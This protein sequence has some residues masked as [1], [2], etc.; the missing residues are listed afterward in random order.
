[1]TSLRERVLAEVRARGLK[2]EDAM[3]RPFRQMA[4]WNTV[5]PSIGVG[6][7]LLIYLSAVG[8]FVIYFVSVFGF[9]QSEANGLGNW[10]WSAMPVAE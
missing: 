1:M 5:I 7:F 6:F 9:S 8:F 3:K 10:F 4:G 2:V